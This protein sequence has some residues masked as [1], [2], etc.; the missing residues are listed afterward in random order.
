MYL[1]DLAKLFAKDLNYCDMGLA[2]R[3]CHPNDLMLSSCLA[4]YLNLGLGHN[5]SLFSEKS[6]LIFLRTSHDRAVEAFCTVEG[7]T[8]DRFSGPPINRAARGRVDPILLRLPPVVVV[9]L[10]SFSFSRRAVAILRPPCSRT[11]PSS[12]QLQPGTC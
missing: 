9:S 11:Q 12:L 5:Y 8:T 10:P 4:D 2:K 7:T 3:V 1:V 6:A